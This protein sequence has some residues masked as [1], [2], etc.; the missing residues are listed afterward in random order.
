MRHVDPDLLALLAL[1]ENAGDAADRDHIA[2][3]A[4]CR[5]EVEN[6]AHAAE[7]GRSTLGAGDLLTPDARVWS[8]I[9]AEVEEL[10]G[11]EGDDDSEH[12]R[13]APV[14]PLRRPG[15][16]APVAAVAAAVV[17]VGGIGAVWLSLQPTPAT[18]LASAQL[19]AFPDWVGATG[20]ATVTESA[21]GSR[22]VDVSVD[23]PAGEE[24]FREVWLISSDTSQLV[25][26]G[27]VD[28]ARGT[29]TIPAGLDLSRY[30]LVDISEEPFDGDPTHSGDSIVR[31]Q[32]S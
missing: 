20:S 18:V 6:L 17:V 3:C 28:G 7:V 5:S 14:T 22:V 10:E 15:W 11:E 27:I 29:F 30:D 25:S 8:A 23:L 12:E 2:S 32:L 31:G 21:D 4:L 13:L 16:I 19:D 1:G 26:L 9:R 24:G